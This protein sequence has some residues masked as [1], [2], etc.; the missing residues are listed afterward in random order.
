M[1]V[2]PITAFA[3]AT[4][5]VDMDE[6][7]RFLRIRTMSVESGCFQQES[8][9][10]LMADQF[11]PEMI[12]NI[13]QTQVARTTREVVYR[14]PTLVEAT[15]KWLDQYEQG[16]LTVHVDTSDLTPQVEK[17]D[18]ALS[19]SMDRLMVALVLAGW[20]VGSAIAGTLDISLGAYRLSDLA[21][22]MF[23]IGAGVGAVVTIQALMRL[24]QEVEEE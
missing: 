23:L 24:N 9:R 18:Q 3:A 7:T 15:T 19:K 16:R 10:E 17:L 22:Y 2:L 21:F 12:G 6:G 11:T 14:I 20:L 5:E 1:S 4:T 13:V 8:G